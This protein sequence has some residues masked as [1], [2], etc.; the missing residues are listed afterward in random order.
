MGTRGPVPERSDQVRRRNAPEIPIEK[1]E[2]GT[3]DVVG[4]DLNLEDAHQ[5]AADWYESLRGSAQAKF[6]EP[7][8]WQMARVAAQCLSDYMADSKRS[9]MKFQAFQAATSP[10]LVTEGDRRRVRM[11]IDRTPP[12]TAAHDAKVAV[13]DRY[14]R[15]ASSG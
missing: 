10:L 4:P 11:E 7:S 12:D 6:Y 2:G 1:V 5:L 3:V 9:A 13:M 14:R 8:D 15:V